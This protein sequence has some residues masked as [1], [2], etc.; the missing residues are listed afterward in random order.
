V[1]PPS[2]RPA[3]SLGCGG[4]AEE[5]ELAIV[6]ILFGLVPCVVGAS[7]VL[8]RCGRRRRES[9]PVELARTASRVALVV[10]PHRT[11]GP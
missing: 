7:Y 5:S 9:G 1:V 6:Q 10:R 3:A 11:S 2:E 8:S 4:D